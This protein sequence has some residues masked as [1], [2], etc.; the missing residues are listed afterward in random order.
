MAAAPSKSKPAS[1]PAI[2]PGGRTAQQQFPFSHHRISRKGIAIIKAQEN[3]R[4]GGTY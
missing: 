4:R 2:M 3:G 1:P